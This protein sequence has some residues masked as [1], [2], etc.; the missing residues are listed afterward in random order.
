MKRKGTGY[1]AIWEAG[2]ANAKAGHLPKAG[3]YL[4][5]AYAALDQ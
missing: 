5:H 3:R 2:Q 4:A 1:A